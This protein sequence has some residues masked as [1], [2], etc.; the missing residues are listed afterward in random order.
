MK[1]TDFLK[2]AIAGIVALAA[3]SLSAFAKRKG[4][5]EPEKPPLTPGNLNS[6]FARY[7]REKHDRALN[8]AITNAKAFVNKYFSYISP[9]QKE[10]I[11][12]LRKS[13]WEGI[14]NIIRD[15]KQGRGTVE[16]KF[17]N[18]PGI[19]DVIAE[20]SIETYLKQPGASDIVLRK[21]VI[22]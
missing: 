10:R 1:R 17:I 20:C 15:M 18:K 13:D 2:K 6:F 9:Q 22:Q 16:F 19:L 14:Q 4:V 3:I 21:F 11:M 5:K 12:R 8:E 7:E